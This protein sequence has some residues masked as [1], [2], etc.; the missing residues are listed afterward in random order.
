M[1]KTS[2]RPLCAWL[3]LA[4]LA[5]LFALPFLW[6]VSTSLKTDAQVFELPPRWLP[7]PPRWH[8][9]PEALAAFPFGLYLGNTLFLCAA[10]VAG[11]LFSCALPAYAFARIPFR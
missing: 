3:A 7:R 1:A 8:N 6:M 9:Y 5:I 11:S 4:L 2:W 10:N